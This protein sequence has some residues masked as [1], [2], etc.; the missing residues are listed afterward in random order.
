MRVYLL[1]F[2]IFVVI[3]SLAMAQQGFV[4]GAGNASCG[5][6]ILGRADT[7][8]SFTLQSDR[9]SWVMGYI[10]A[11]NIFVGHSDVAKGTD[12]KGLF[13]W[14]DN[15]CANNPLDTVESA[16]FSLISQLRRRQE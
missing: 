2:T 16:T 14:I 7:K 10:S 4:R 9:E 5:A 12:P 1:I 15:F 13:G 6:W 11:Y 3:P 8:G